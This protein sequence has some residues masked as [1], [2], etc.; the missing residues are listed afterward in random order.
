MFNRSKAKAGGRRLRATGGVPGMLEVM[1]LAAALFVILAPSYLSEAMAGVE[2]QERLNAFDSAAPAASTSANAAKPGLY[3]LRCWQHG[4][5]VLE[6]NEVQ[7][8]PELAAGMKLRG[9][10]R[11][12]RAVYLAETANATCLVRKH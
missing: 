5:L 10:D 8:P 2:P 4:R 12:K 3:Q 9:T 6:E 11:T 1:L 7:L